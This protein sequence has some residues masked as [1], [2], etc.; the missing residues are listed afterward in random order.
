MGKL[1]DDYFV[2][3]KAPAKA[4]IAAKLAEIAAVKADRKTARVAKRKARVEAQNPANAIE[5][6]RGK[7]SIVLRLADDLLK[8]ID[9]AVTAGTYRSR[10]AAIT[11]IL[12]EGTPK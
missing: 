9:Q 5:P 2:K 6:T 12:E 4:P 8:R 3:K 10:N 11:A 1:Y 7:V